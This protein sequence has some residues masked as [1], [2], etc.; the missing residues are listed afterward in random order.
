MDWGGRIHFLT[1]LHC[2][3]KRGEDGGLVRPGPSCLGRP[4]IL[5]WTIS[6]T[7]QLL[8]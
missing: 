3:G 5:L 7:K 8:S 4:K 6:A 2:S 1:L